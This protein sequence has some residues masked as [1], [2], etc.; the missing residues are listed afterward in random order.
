MEWLEE[1]NRPTSAEL[2]QS[3]IEKPSDFSG[4]TYPT[5]ISTIRITGD[6]S[7]IESVAGLFIWIVEME[8]Y[9]RRVEI[10]LQRTEDRE[11]G[12]QT[13][14]YALYLSVAERGGS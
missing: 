7:F 9:S 5:D 12:D 2:K 3:M 14:N 10:N 1:L 4:S 6:P 8:D 11:T 13:E